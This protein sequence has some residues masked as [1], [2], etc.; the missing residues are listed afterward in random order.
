MLAIMTVDGRDALDMWL[1]KHSSS[2]TTHGKGTQHRENMVNNAS[3]KPINIEARLPRILHK[4]SFQLW[5]SAIDE[6][7]HFPQ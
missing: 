7:H 2:L 4:V 1:W 5:P 6:R 3:F